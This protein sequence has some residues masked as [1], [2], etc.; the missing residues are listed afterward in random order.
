MYVGFAL[1]FDSLVLIT[2]GCLDLPL[3]PDQIVLLTRREEGKER[4]S[5]P[6]KRKERINAT[7]L[8]VESM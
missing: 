8:I 4:K 1:G 5:K 6:A 7:L 2:T 3:M